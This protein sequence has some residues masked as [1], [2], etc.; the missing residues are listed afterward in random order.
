MYRVLKPKGKAYVYIPNYLFPYEHHYKCFFPL[1]PHGLA[2]IYLRL[3]KP[4]WL[5]WCRLRGY[6]PVKT[7]GYVDSLQFI[8]TLG[9]KKRFAGLGA[10]VETANFIHSSII[11]LLIWLGLYKSAW[12]VVT[13]HG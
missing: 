5:W 12:L 3:M 9:I 6:D 11:R 1:M 4:L 8:T 10:K 2:R 7:E 13:K